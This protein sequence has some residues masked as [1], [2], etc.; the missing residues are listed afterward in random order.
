MENLFEK[1]G[2]RAVRR[3]GDEIT[4]RGIKQSVFSRTRLK[5]QSR[6]FR[7]REDGKFAENLFEKKLSSV[8]IGSASGA[9]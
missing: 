1:S 8:F 2:A 6:T 5:F 4:T 9:R 7:S 3:R